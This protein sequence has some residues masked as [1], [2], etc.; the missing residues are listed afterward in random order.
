MRRH[1]ESD[2]RLSYMQVLEQGDN[3]GIVL[4]QSLYTQKSLLGIDVTNLSEMLFL[5]WFSHETLDN[6]V[7]R[8]TRKKHDIWCYRCAA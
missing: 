1:N 5:E 3:V 8:S 6:I 4:R 7:S 2:D